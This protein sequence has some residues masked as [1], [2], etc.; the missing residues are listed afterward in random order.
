MR[1]HKFGGNVVRGSGP[2]RDGWVKGMPMGDEYA[3]VGTQCSK[4]SGGRI[5]IP[6]DPKHGAAD[7]RET[8]A[9]FCKKVFAANA[10]CAGCR[11]RGIAVQDDLLR[12]FKRC[13]QLCWIGRGPEPKV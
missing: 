8:F 13:D 11:L 3:A 1:A 7:P 9:Q 2:R 5:M 6:F 10:E 4:F 12:A